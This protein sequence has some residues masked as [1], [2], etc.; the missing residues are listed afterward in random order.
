M[1]V[2]TKK[3]GGPLVPL[4]TTDD[5]VAFTAIKNAHDNGYV[6]G[7]IGGS[8]GECKRF[9]DNMAARFM[10]ELGIRLFHETE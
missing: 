10:D 7:L 6:Y 5:N 2:L 8:S 4:V 3:E 9:I 1:L